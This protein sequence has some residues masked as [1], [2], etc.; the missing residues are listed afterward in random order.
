MKKPYNPILLDAVD[1]CELVDILDEGKLVPI[2]N[3]IFKKSKH[4]F[5]I[6]KDFDILLVSIE[7]NRIVFSFQ[8]SKELKDWFNNFDGLMDKDGLHAGWHR[9][10]KKFKDDILRIVSGEGI[11]K[12][13][14]FFCHSRGGALGVLGAFY[15]AKYLGCTVNIIT[16]GAPLVGDAAF[17]DE[18]REL[19]INSTRCI[20]GRDPVPKVPPKAL[21]YK[22][23]SFIKELYDKAWYYL[24]IPGV[25]FRVHTDY[26]DNI[27]K[28]S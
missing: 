9:C 3:P 15:I 5:S 27:R 10:F 22:C 4:W 21:G 16:F 26:Y 23:E 2:D 19:P 14:F 24:P 18:F 28:W 25:G 20:I 13:V 11:G 7:E 12:K 8:G 1:Y 6:R 17:R